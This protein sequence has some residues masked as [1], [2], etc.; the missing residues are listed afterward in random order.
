MQNYNSTT[1]SAQSDILDVCINQPMRKPAW[2]YA[3]QWESL[4]D[5]TPANGK[6]LLDFTPANDKACLTLRQPMRKPAWL[7]TSQWE[8]LLDFTP[9]NEKACLTLRQP[10]RKPVWLHA[11]QWES[12]LDFTPANEKTCL[13]LRQ[14]MRKPACRWTVRRRPW[15][16]PRTTRCWS[17]AALWWPSSSP[18]SSSPSSSAGAQSELASY[19]TAARVFW[20]TGLPIGSYD[21]LNIELDFQSLFGLLYT[22]VFFGWD[23]RNYPPPP[24]FGLIYEGAVGRPR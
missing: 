12:P 23:P 13:T 11:S 3:R 4:L 6:S 22:A 18:P 5:F 8:S 9:T 15:W 2:L 20:K 17:W 14:P 24:A 21:R 7:Y 16:R 10:M 1:F 19:W